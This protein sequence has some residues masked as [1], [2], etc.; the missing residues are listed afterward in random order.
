MST[1]VKLLERDKQRLDRL[2]GEIMARHGRR[3]PQQEVLSRLLDLAEAD[4]ER[5]L[6]DTS[7]PMTP[8]EIA[9][10]RRL[11]VSTGVLTREEE[12]DRVIAEATL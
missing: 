3:V 7:R 1:S 6:E 2:Q 11:V 12:L 4:K 5:L 9:S 10:L 8:R